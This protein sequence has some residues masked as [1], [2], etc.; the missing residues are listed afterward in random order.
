MKHDRV[1]KQ[2]TERAIKFHQALKR[3]GIYIVD[4]SETEFWQRT[5]NAIDLTARNL[6]DGIGDPWAAV[7]GFTGSLLHSLSDVIYLVT[8]DTEEGGGDLFE[9]LQKLFERTQFRFV[10]H[11]DS[12]QQQLVFQ[13]DELIWSVSCANLDEPQLWI[14]PIHFSELEPRLF[15][16]LTAR[17]WM[18]YPV[19]TG[20]QIAEFVLMR[21]QAIDLIKN[22]LISIHDPRSE[23]L[24]QG[25]PESQRPEDIWLLWDETAE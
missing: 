14:D 8:W 5:A 16:Y 25:I 4:V 3:A 2:L 12:T 22:Y 1:S 10:W 13:I 18:L 19:S 11:F 21:L 20:D 7:L 17:G 9:S 15:R 23:W 6:I 24:Y